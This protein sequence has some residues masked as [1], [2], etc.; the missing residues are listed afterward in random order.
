MEGCQPEYKLY[1]HVICNE[2]L[3]WLPRVEAHRYNLTVCTLQHYN[4]NNNSF[5]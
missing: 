4:N 5:T 2:V 1:L 3:T